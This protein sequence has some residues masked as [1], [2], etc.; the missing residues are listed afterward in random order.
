[1]LK[2]NK[3]IAFSLIASLFLMATIGTLVNA[4]T[5]GTAIVLS[6]T[7][8]TTTPAAGTYNYAD[9][10]TQSFRANAQDPFVFTGWIVTAGG[11]SSTSMDNPIEL[12][13]IAGV[14]YEIQ[15]NFT[16]VEPVPGSNNLPTNMGSAAIVKLLAS[17]GGT[18]DPSPATYAFDDATSFNI[19]AIP[20]EGWQFQYWIISG[21]TDSHG[22]YPFTLNPTS[23]PYNINHGYGATY[24]Y[25]AV[26]TLIGS[27]VPTPTGGAS[28][29]PSDGVFAGLSMEWIII[30]AL[31]VIIVIMLIGFGIVM[32]R[33]H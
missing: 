24:N 33:R 28:P 19:R 30:I 11:V 31:A 18:T 1:M 25:Q 22:G 16:P 7:G 12:P 14:T 21:P 4:Q 20:D 9:G 3:I 6:S 27:E 26:F 23:N 29:T 32:T 17:A 10:T 2:R 8:G 5:Q 13:M 15:P